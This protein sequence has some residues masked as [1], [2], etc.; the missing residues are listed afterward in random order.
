ML[1][2]GCRSVL[3]FSESCRYVV[4]DEQRFL[5]VNLHVSKKR[6]FILEQNDTKAY[7]TVETN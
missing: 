1:V 5:R 2:L 4:T 6:G 7:F 3:S